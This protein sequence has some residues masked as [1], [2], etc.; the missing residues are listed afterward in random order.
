MA[1][2]LLLIFQL[3]KRGVKGM[4][5]TLEEPVELGQGA[6]TTDWHDTF[7]GL[8]PIIGDMFD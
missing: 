1:C 3:Q 6:V 5:P 2:I 7:D 8:E 4:I